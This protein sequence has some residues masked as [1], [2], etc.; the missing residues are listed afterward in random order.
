MILSR[1]SFLKMAGLTVVAAAGASM[2]TGCG[3][4][5]TTPIKVVAA[6]DSTKEF[7]AAVAAVSYTHLT[8]P[9]T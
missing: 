5:S 6:K 2:F 4:F 3:A 1:R 8:L 9:T 7:Q